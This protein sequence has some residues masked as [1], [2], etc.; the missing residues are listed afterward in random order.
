MYDAIGPSTTTQNGL[1]SGLTGL[2][3]VRIGVTPPTFL[4]MTLDLDYFLYQ[5]SQ[6]GAGS[7]SLGKEFDAKLSYKVE[8]RLLIRLVG[9]FFTAGTGIRPQGTGN[10]SG[11]KFSLEVSGR[12]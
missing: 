4:G 3:V 1:P 9:A 5:A 6:A 7:R 8:D 11:R 10:A 12:F 2:R